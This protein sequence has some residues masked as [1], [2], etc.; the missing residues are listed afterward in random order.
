MCT[1]P[2]ALQVVGAHSPLLEV[3]AGL[4]HWQRELAG[5]GVDIVAGEE[6]VKGRG[7]AGP[8]GLPRGS[9]PALPPSAPPPSAPTP[10]EPHPPPSRPSSY[11]SPTVDNYSQLPTH[12]VRMDA[13]QFV[14]KVRPRL[15]AVQCSAVRGVRRGAGLRTTRQAQQGGAGWLTGIDRVVGMGRRGHALSTQPE[16]VPLLPCANAPP[17]SQTMQVEKG[18]ESAVSKYPRRTVGVH[19]CVERRVVGGWL[20][21]WN[22]RMAGVPAQ[23]ANRTCNR[24]TRPH[25]AHAQSAPRPACPA[26]LLLVYPG[27]EP[28]A[29]AALAKYK[30][31]TL[32][33]VGE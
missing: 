32:L 16:R 4:G 29:A 8:W 5:R 23:D 15:P 19:L 1:V 3:G 14:G 26:Q 27:P 12:D 24:Q 18:D 13:P 28:M 2:Q 10:F 6:R 9:L 25:H 7:L 31:N 20:G 17:A 21:T 22:S 33:Y 11:P 30:G